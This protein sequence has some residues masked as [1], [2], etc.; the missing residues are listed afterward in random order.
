LC[1]CFC[2]K[3]SEWFEIRIKEWFDIRI[4]EWFEIRS[5]SWKCNLGLPNKTYLRKPILSFF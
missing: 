2:K 4:K 1:A 5:F 3:G